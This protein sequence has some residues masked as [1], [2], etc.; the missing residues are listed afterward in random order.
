MEVI[1]G[2]APNQEVPAKHPLLWDITTTV[3]VT[4]DL[5]SNLSIIG[6]Q[7]LLYRLANGSMTS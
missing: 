3:T 6:A 2:P 1:Y 7:P 5:G 4:K